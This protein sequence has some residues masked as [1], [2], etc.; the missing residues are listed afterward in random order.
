MV[1]RHFIILIFHF[2]FI[3]GW[4][5]YT[6]CKLGSELVKVSYACFSF[7]LKFFSATVDYYSFNVVATANI[8]NDAHYKRNTEFKKNR[9]KL[10]QWYARALNGFYCAMW[11]TKIVNKV[12]N[13]RFNFQFI[14]KYSV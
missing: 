6:N 8:W 2:S 9:E 5:R 4:E 3:F 10:K 1:I 13:C 14:R 7:T 11:V 12:I